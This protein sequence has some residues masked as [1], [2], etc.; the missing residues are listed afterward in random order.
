MMLS[1]C[2]LSYPNN[3][4]N[5]RSYIMYRCVVYI[6]MLY[7]Q[8]ILHYFYRNI[9]PNDDYVTSRNTIHYKQVLSVSNI[10]LQNICPKN[11][12]IITLQNT[13]YLYYIVIHIFSTVLRLA[14]HKQLIKQQMEDTGTSV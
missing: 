5:Y 6:S 2:V 13:Y 7:V 3:N 4:F 8:K 12:Y 10:Y 9:N 1:H 11:S 14:N